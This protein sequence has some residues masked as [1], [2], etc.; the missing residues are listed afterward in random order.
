MNFLTI[1]IIGCDFAWHSIAVT[2]VVTGIIGNFDMPFSRVRNFIDKSQWPVM[3]ITVD[4]HRFNPPIS[5]PV[6]RSK[7]SSCEAPP[8]RRTAARVE[9][10]GVRQT[11]ATKQ[12]GS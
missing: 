9:Y 11:S 10:V 7:H 2:K 6:S 4:I 12:M 5:L 3:S 8:L 1:A